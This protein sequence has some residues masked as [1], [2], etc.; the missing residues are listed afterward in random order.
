[1]GPSGV[2]GLFA[3]AF[4]LLPAALNINISCGISYWRI[5]LDVWARGR[6]FVKI[7]IKEILKPVPSC[8]SLAETEP[9]VR[10]LAGEQVPR[11]GSGARAC[12]PGSGR[13]GG[14]RAGLC[15]LNTSGAGGLALQVSVQQRTIDLS[16]P[17][18]AGHHKTLQSAVQS[19][20]RG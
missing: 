9:A 12:G 2:A 10:A 17:E 20:A 3:S 1:M 8:Y 7:F 18:T 6:Q 15:M 14:Q 16:F 4:I 5:V 13:R 19:A 11:R